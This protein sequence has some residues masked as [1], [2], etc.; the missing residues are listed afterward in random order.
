MAAQKAMRIAR[1]TGVCVVSSVLI[2]CLN[3]VEYEAPN[4]DLPDRYALIAPVPVSASG[5]AQWWRSFDDPLLNDLIVDVLTDNLDI[6]EAEERVL[7]AQAVARR[8]GNTVSGNLGLEA[9]ASSGIDTAGADISL[10]LDPFGS[11][12]KEADA[13][14]ERLEAARFGL[15]NAK[16]I[17][18]S[19]LMFAY[20]DL[21]F[22]QQNLAYR[23][24]DLASREE[25]LSANGELLQQGAATRLDEVRLE[26]LV[27]EARADIPRLSSDVTR[28]ENIIAT[29]LGTVPQNLEVNLSYM[30]KQ[31]YPSNITDVGVP[32]DLLRRRPD[33]R[34]AERN[35]AAAVSEINAAEAARYPSLS[36]SGDITTPLEGSGGSV[37]GAGIGLNVPVFNQPGLIA[38]V[39]VNAS[40]AAQ[41]YLEWSQLVLAAIADVETAL[42]AVQKSREQVRAAQTSLQLNLEALELS[43]DIFTGVGSITVVDIL[44]AERSVTAA[45]TT[46]ALAIREHAREVIAL[47]TALGIGFDRDIVMSEAQSSRNGLVKFS[48]IREMLTPKR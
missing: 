40:L 43:Q 8:E 11:E 17:V 23:R 46:L 39:D 42:V 33:I 24:Q 12:R 47:Y 38:Q 44:D 27:A 5:S 31:P 1:L 25:S 16:L 21:R 37:R 45:R 22:F 2:G 41:A 36:L 13:A 10:V 6:K 34:A 18:G 4:L 14:L 26:A 19:E 48:E 7:E 3:I 15:Q 9:N 30:G 32:A 20:V 28:Q 29:L 35:Y